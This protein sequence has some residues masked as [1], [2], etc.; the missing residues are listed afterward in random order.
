MIEQLTQLVR[1]H[2]QDTVVNNP[3]V[4]NENNDAVIGAASETI[5]SG[6]QEQ[7]AAGN[8]TQVLSLLGGNE[9]GGLMNNPIVKSIIGKFT[10]TLSEKFN[11]N[12]ASAQEMA[13][14][15]IPGVLGSLVQKT[16]DPNN[17][18]FNLQGILNA[19]TGGQAGG[20]NLDGIMGKLK[21]GLDKDGDGDV[22]FNDITSMLSSGARQ[23]Q[24]SGGGIGG[25]IKNLLG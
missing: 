24:E 16:N 8:A 20:L 3:A 5:A 25:F 19:L 14:S 21:G 2:A 15:L 18:S 13:G 7:L 12:G 22:D 4:P 11:V 1:E 17:N 10:G 6:L 23:Q 9:S